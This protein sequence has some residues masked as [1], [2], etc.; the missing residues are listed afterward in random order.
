MKIGLLLGEGILVLGLAFIYSSLK[1]SSKISENEE[2]N[3]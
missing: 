3:N 1:L 2:E